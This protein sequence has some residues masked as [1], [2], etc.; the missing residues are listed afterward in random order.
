MTFQSNIAR[1]KQDATDKIV[2]VNDMSYQ[3]LLRPELI[4]DVGAQTQQQHDSINAWSCRKQRLP[5][6]ASVDEVEVS[7]HV[8]GPLPFDQSD[9]KIIR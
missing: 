5:A 6:S 9:V 2:F 8:M 7:L 4:F 1:D 3:S